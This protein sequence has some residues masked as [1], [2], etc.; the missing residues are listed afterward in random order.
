[1]CNIE[2]PTDPYNA[3]TNFGERGNDA[4]TQMPRLGPLAGDDC[5]VGGEHVSH[6]VVGV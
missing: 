1:M 5:T 3:V 6:F 2:S 4:A